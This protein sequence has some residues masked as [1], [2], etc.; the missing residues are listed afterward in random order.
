MDSVVSG[1]AEWATGFEPSPADLDLASRALQDTLAVTVAAR[2]DPIRAVL[3]DLSEAGRW[4]A[5]GHVLDFDDLNVP[6]TAHLSVICIPAVL[7]SGGG[8]R[9]YL[10]AAGAMSRL[11]IALGWQHYASGWHTTCTAGAPAAAVGAAIA[12]GLDL[13]GIRRAL[14]LA[15]PGAGGVQ[16][17]FGTQAKA[18][19]VGFA[20]DA[21]LRA[22]RLAA[23]GA[24]ADP[25]AFDQ[26]LE[27]LGG[28]A[29]RVSWN[30][31]SIPGGLAVKLYPCCYA[32][33]RPITGAR[34]LTGCA[35]VSQI[36][37]VIART[38]Q[39]TIRPLIHSR[40]RTGLEAKFSL[41]Y[42]L[43]ASFLD[44]Y[45]GLGSFSDAA[46]NR[47][48]AKSLSERVEV[49]ASPDGDSLL[50]GD[51]SLEVI[52]NNGRQLKATLVSPP[53]SPE[54]P[55]TEN[56]MSSKLAECVGS[57]VAQLSE[58]TWE[59]ASAFLRES[60]EPSRPNIVPA[61]VPAPG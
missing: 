56:Q 42:G 44:D 32:L 41:E 27:L 58:M 39:A 48:A 20:V 59:A 2:S 17:A 24:S 16:H 37:K 26:W 53:G 50:A 12:M 11:G 25:S 51:F 6:S 60:L 35:D 23:A 30:G 9:A 22:A 8:S 19:Q 36:S 40:P 45:P 46:V 5:L 14:A 38:S 1:I 15:V 18:L 31:P 47:Q 28:D 4:A 49:I 7:A 54:L 13:A 3:V 33:Q 61:D 29:S 55:P 52:L 43:A 57:R 10:A 34:Q 21:G